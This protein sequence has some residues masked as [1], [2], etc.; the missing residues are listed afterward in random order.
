MKLS[1]QFSIFIIIIREKT[2][3]YLYL[4]YIGTKRLL[5]KIIL[6]YLTF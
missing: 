5:D 6:V 2:S 4:M 1:T 3:N